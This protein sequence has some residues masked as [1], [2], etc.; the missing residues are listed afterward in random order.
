MSQQ[1]REI[2]HSSQRA[3][4]TTK[5]PFAVLKLQEI[6]FFEYYYQFIYIIVTVM[7]ITFKSEFLTFPRQKYFDWE[8]TT[9]ICLY[10]LSFSK[11][12]MGNIGNKSENSEVVS[13]FLLLNFGTIIGFI[14]LM[15]FQT[16]VLQL[17]FIVNLIGLSF[18]ILGLLFGVLAN[19]SFKASE[20]SMY[21]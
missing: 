1:Q 12:K 7:C 10:V 13:S 9:Q 4:S 14:F 20:R 3:Q 18:A 21:N 6:L 8:I 11:V 5:I 16:F 17:E 15:F 19:S 2:S